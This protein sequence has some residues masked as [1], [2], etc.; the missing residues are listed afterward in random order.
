M[1]DKAWAYLAILSMGNPSDETKRCV[2]EILESNDD[3]ST[4]RMKLKD[5]IKR[6]DSLKEYLKV[7]GDK[8]E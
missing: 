7:L 8:T 3:F 1:I 6:D 2:M 4:M 5:A